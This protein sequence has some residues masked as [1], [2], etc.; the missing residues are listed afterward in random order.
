MP[1]SNVTPIDWLRVWVF[2]SVRLEHVY[3][4]RDSRVH[5]PPYL[6]IP[7]GSYTVE[8]RSGPTDTKGGRVWTGVYEVK[9]LVGTDGELGSE[10]YARRWRRMF[11]R[12]YQREA[13]PQERHECPCHD[14]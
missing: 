10:W 5:S 1:S 8:G 6:L 2:C 4:T 14:K 3:Q 7:V 13:T 11:M 12:Q 9:S